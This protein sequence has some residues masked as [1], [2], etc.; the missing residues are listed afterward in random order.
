MFTAHVSHPFTEEPVYVQ[1]CRCL[2]KAGFPFTEPEFHV[3]INPE[4]LRAADIG[5]ADKGTYFHISPFTTADSKELPPEQL[6]EFIVAMAKLFP[7]KRWVISC[8]PTKRELVKLEKFLPLLPFKPWRAFPGNL[9]LTQLAAVIRHAALHCSADSGPLHLAV[10]T[11][12][13]TVAWFRS[14]P[15]LRE[16]MPTG[17]KYRVLIGANEPGAMHLGNIAAADLVSAAQ[18]ILKSART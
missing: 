17:E 18:S 8:A 1:R 4:H 14:H 2:E 11:D 3:E 12:M 16:W 5:S 6:V 13:P 9:N 7:E 10:M 15:S